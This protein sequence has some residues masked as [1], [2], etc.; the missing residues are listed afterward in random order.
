MP[1]RFVVHWLNGN[2]R[3]V[4]CNNVHAPFGVPFVTVKVNAVP[5]TLMPL[6]SPGP[7]MANGWLLVAPRKFMSANT[8]F[9]T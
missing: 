2:A 8:V 7:L 9:D 4:P 3:F 5:L 6:K 1:V